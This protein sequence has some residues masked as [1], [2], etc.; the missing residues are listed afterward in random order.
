VSI[1]I[2]FQILALAGGYVST[3]NELLGE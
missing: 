2:A 3:L 1:W